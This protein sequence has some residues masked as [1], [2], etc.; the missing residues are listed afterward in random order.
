MKPVAVVAI[1]AALIAVG[2]ARGSAQKEQIVKLTATLTPTPAAK[3]QGLTAGTGTFNAILSVTKKTITWTVQVD[4]MSGPPIAEHIHLTFSEGVLIPLCEPCE[5][6]TTGKMAFLLPSTIAK[7]RAKN[8]AYVQVHTDKVFLGEI[9]GPI[10][11][12][13]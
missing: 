3:A 6:S 10:R 4:A 1:A 2:V 12:V 5:A 7:L 11:V 8:S 9:S 13:K